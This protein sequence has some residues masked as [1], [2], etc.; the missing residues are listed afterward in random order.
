MAGDPSDGSTPGTATPPALLEVGRIGRAH[1]LRGEVVVQLITNV[2]ERL[3][4]GSVLLAGP[5]RRPLTVE[6]S[7]PHQQRWIVSFAGVADRTAA[8]ALHGLALFAERL[9]A[10]VDPDALWVHDLI[11]RVVIDQ[12]GVRRGVVESVQDN[13]AS[14]LLVLDSGA[15]VPLTFLV[16]EGE[17]GVLRVDVPAGLFDD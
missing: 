12:D 16:D 17:P 3:A 10:D 7:R 1:A 2:T 14:D 9:A 8:E 13:P 6:A 15:L 4:P 11:G 5:A